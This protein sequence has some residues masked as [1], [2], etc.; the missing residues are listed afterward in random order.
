MES[1][2]DEGEARWVD[3]EGACLGD[4]GTEEIGEDDK[5]PAMEDVFWRGMRQSPNS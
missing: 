5:V 4:E 1:P 3:A 2:A